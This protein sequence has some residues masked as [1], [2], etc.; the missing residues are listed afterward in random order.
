M[1]IKN[2]FIT[3]SSSTSFIISSKG[4]LKRMEYKIE[5][6]L[7]SLRHTV[8]KNMEDL[9]NISY[10]EDDDRND[11]VSH[12]N[13]GETVYYFYLATDDCDAVGSFIID[14]GIDI[15][16]FKTKTSLKII[17]EPEGI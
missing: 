1:K 8:I 9:S 16:N 2:D 5:I 10:L 3:N 6:D 7:L 15:K 12:I 13:K 17:R 4:E 14:N 11:I